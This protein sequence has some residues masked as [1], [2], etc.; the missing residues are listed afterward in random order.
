MTAGHIYTVAGNGTSGFAGDGGAAVQ[1]EM[2]Q[3]TGIVVDAAG[4]LVIAD[5]LNQRLRVVAAKT[6]TFHRPGDLAVAD[7]GNNRVRLIAP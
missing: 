3:P 1:A 2:N 6:G 4:N 7:S 5:A